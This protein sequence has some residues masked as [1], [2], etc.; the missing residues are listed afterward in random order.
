MSRPQFTPKYDLDT[1]TA[2]P[3]L[4]WNRTQEEAGGGITMRVA[5]RNAGPVEVRAR[6][7]SIRFDLPYDRDARALY[8]A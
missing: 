3:M 1:D 7:A 6:A 2:Q 5:V 4:E 8:I